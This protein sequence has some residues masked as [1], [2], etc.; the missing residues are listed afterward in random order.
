MVIDGENVRGV[1]NVFLA[2]EGFTASLKPSQP[3][4]LSG[5]PFDVTLTTQ[6]PAG[7]PAGRQ[8]TLFVLQRQVAKPNPILR[9][10]PW[11]T[12]TRQRVEETTVQE[13]KVAT[14]E[15]T[16]KG[17][18]RLTLEKGGTYILR[19]AGEDRFKQTVSAESQVKISD[20]EDDTKLRFF[21]QSDTLQVGAQAKL[22]LHSRI[23]GGLALL[24]LE[25]EEIIEHRVITLKKNF[26]E[27][28]LDVDHVHFPNF[29]ACVNAM[30]GRELRIA[31]KAFTVERQL[32]VSVKPKEETYEPAAE[33]EVEIS[34]TDQ[35]GKPVEGELS[36]ALVDEALYSQFG[37]AIPH[38]RDFFQKDARRHADFRASSSVGFAYTAPTRKVIKELLDEKT[39]LARREE[40][41]KRL[42]QAGQQLEG[43][44]L[45]LLGNDAQ[46]ELQE[47]MDKDL[48]IAGERPSDM[49][50]NL[51][52]PNAPGLSSQISGRA[53]TNGRLQ[54]NDKSLSLGTV[55]VDSIDPFN[56][57]KGEAMFFFRDGLDAGKANLRV[58]FAA[59]LGEKEDE[60]EAAGGDAAI[61]REMAGVGQWLPV[62]VTDAKGKATAK[63]TLPNSASE[64][65][66]TA[67]GVTVQTLVGQATAKVVTRKDFFVSLKAPARLQEGD[68]LRALGRVHNLTDYEGEVNL[69]L[70]LLGGEDFDKQLSERKATVKITKQGVAEVLMDA[71]GIPL[72]ANVRLQLTATAGEKLADTFARTFPVRPWG[73]EY[74]DHEGG[75]ATGDATAIVSLPADRRDGS[76]WLTITVGPNLKQSV[77]DMALG[78]ALTPW[79]KGGI[80]R[81]YWCVAPSRIGGFTG[82]D[83]LAATA[84]LEFARTAK[85]GPAELKRLGNRIRTLVGSLVVSQQKDGGWVWQ[86]QGVGSHWGITATSFWALCA[87]RDADIPVHADTINK[88][89]NYLR[90]RFTQL[91]ANDND[92]KA[93]L[94]H[95]LSV[96]KAADFAHANR[97]HRERN[98]LSAPALAYTA[99]AF[100]N[101]DRKEFGAEL[102]DVLVKKLATKKAGKKQLLS[103]PGVRNNSWTSEETETTALAAL[104]FMRARPGAAPIQGLIDYLMNRR[105]AYGFSAAKARGPAVAA[106]AEFYAQGKFAQDNYKLTIL[107]N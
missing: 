32:K 17:T 30:D 25:G 43:R 68:S 105:G 71:I 103:A 62:I 23:E 4:A 85:A 22:R 93:V 39:R 90:T 100:V 34:V 107:V 46:R 101:L 79:A 38:I 75:V 15:K 18:V 40:E 51:F 20:E 59:N 102:L 24:T 44:Q 96:N 2:R 84:A 42:A 33:A 77:I 6:T 50:S 64:W 36:L 52:V 76:Q 28:N 94:L 73:L 9:A 56:S 21:A 69:T 1:H 54:L 63:F 81:R 88:A 27:I 13:H 5:E 29:N 41:T 7:K 87:A 72:T 70:Q 26:N 80:N 16:G 35:L 37:D 31:Q 95:A 91:N 99:L 48:E 66:L 3:L 8:L 12:Q 61:R 67:R 83:L 86:A 55:I 89:Q 19:V 60:G 49:P 98:T 11:T 92:A 14:D 74:A 58:N 82:S 47:E 104:A 10:M 57:H 45:L 106:V 53:F 65:R 78:N 97:L